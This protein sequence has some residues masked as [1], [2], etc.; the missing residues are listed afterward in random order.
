MTRTISGNPN[1][2]PNI[3]GIVFLYP[4]VSPEDKSI[5]L[6]GPGDITVDMV[7]VAIDKTIAIV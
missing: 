2:I 1:I 3:S 7:N 6:F 4:K 5:I